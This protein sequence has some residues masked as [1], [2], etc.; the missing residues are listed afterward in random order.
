MVVT[1]S[2]GIADAPEHRRAAPWKT[3]LCVTSKHRAIKPWTPGELGQC[4]IGTAASQKQYRRGARFYRDHIRTD[5]EQ[6]RAVV[7]ELEARI[8]AEIWPYP[9]YGEL[10]YSVR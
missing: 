10:L 5:M 9:D 2:C 4:L 3:A 1:R 8:P 7:D 6:L